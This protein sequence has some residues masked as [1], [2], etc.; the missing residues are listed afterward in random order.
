MSSDKRERQK[1]NRSSKVDANTR[2]SSREV[3][4]QR[5]LLFVVVFALLLGGLYLLTQTGNDTAQETDVTTEA[6][7][8]DAPSADD[9]NADG[10]GAATNR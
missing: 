3:L 9:E 4:R 6:G 7:G 1:A 5:V 8:G 2:L 10:T